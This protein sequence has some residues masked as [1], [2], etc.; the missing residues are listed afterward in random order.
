[1]NFESGTKHPV[2]I[3]HLE[4]SSLDI[5]LMEIQLKALTFPF[6][7]TRVSTE[8]EFRAVLS[9]KSVDL[10]VSDSNLPGFDTRNALAFVRENYPKVPFI[11]FSGQLSPK[12]QEMAFSDGA[13]AFIDKNDPGR[14]VSMIE[15]FCNGPRKL[16]AVGHALVVQC[17]GFRCLAYLTD[18]GRWV[19]CLQHQELPEV[20]SWYDPTG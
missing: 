17:R 9:D 8:P 4:D 1:M 14:L 7:L 3:L 18:K 5:E 10:V 13:C 11:F 20:L 6:S 16:P 15:Q 19:D 2:Q 12:I